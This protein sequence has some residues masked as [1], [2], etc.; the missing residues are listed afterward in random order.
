[1]KDLISFC[2]RFFFFFSSSSK[3]PTFIRIALHFFSF[4]LFHIYILYIV[5]SFPH[6][7]GLSGRIEFPPAHIIFDP[8]ALPFSFMYLTTV[9]P[10][11]SIAISPRPVYRYDRFI[12]IIIIDNYHTPTNTANFT[13]LLLAFNTEFYSQHPQT[14]ESLFTLLSISFSFFRIKIKN[15]HLKVIKS[16]IN[17]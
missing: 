9:T 17:K 3:Y 12:V 6:L 7:H 2:Y 4:Y 15:K 5:E 14:T 1:M 8:S 16:K 11:I 10:Y 13:S